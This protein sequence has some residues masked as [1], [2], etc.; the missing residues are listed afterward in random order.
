MASNMERLGI[1]QTRRAAVFYNQ[2]RC[3]EQDER[4]RKLYR[5]NFDELIAENG[6]PVGQPNVM[7]NGW[8][9]D[10]SRTLPGIDELIAESEQIIAERG[11]KATKRPDT[12]RAF[13]QNIA[14]PAD[15]EKYPSILNFALSSSALTTVCKYM[16]SIPVLSG[17]LPPGIRLAESS[18]SFDAKPAPY[19][20]SQLFH[21]D[22]YSDPMVYIIVLLRDVTA[23][24]GPFRWVPAAES[25]AAVSKL[26]YW[27]KGT[28]Y[29][30]Q[31][32]T[33]Y[34]VVDPKSVHELAYPK[35]T[36]LFIDP[37]RCFHY[38]SRDAVIPRY[39]MMYGFSPVCRTDLSELMMKPL[40]YHV[41]AQDSRLRKLVLRSDY[42]VN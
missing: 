26:K 4:R 36:V 34:S 31:D 11:L 1:R 37:S 20:D 32:D 19:R 23:K 12:Y 9:L 21:L 25:Q 38:G 41:R 39:Q 16:Q 6:A 15:T 14:K 29:R 18:A 2:F 10:T 3:K 42:A 40:C 33:V 28:P 13:F 30:L 7:K 22:Y 35:G 24:S 8:A 5:E 27:E 17:T